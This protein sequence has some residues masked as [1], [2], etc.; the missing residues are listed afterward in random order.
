MHVTT[1]SKAGRKAERVI[2]LFQM[3]NG[4]GGLPDIIR[5]NH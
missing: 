3:G 2:K 4:K 5:L 1:A